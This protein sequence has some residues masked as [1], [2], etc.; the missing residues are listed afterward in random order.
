[1]QCDRLVWESVSGAVNCN[2]SFLARSRPSPTDG[3]SMMV[4]GM[5]TGHT[6][7]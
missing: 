6:S 7:T 2:K 1:M 4:K 3:H 5:V